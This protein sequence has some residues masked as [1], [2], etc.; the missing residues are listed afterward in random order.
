[1]ASYQILMITGHLADVTGLRSQLAL[2]RRDSDEPDLISKEVNDSSQKMGKDAE[3]I[4]GSCPLLG[5]D[6]LI[7]KRR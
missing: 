7:S 5:I 2:T 4:Y 6:E 1:M 3:K